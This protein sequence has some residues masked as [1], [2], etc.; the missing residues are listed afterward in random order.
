MR[1]GP[2]QEQAAINGYYDRLMREVEIEQAERDY[3][4]SLPSEDEVLDRH[5]AS[6]EARFHAQEKAE[7]DRLAYESNLPT[8]DEIYK[9]QVARD[10]ARRAEPDED[11][12]FR[13]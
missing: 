1:G 9:Q 13:L 6:E 8:E 12:D 4:A 5:L 3:E 10:E 7:Q 11:E 2:E